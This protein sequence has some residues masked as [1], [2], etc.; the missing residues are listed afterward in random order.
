M[1]FTLKKEMMKNMED[2]MMDAVLQ[3]EQEHESLFK[4]FESKLQSIRDKHPELQDDLMVMEEIMVEIGT[5]GELYEIG[6]KQAVSIVQ[7]YGFQTATSLIV[8]SVQSA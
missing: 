1:K 5:A 7:D 3:Q 2:L 8:P 6:F 4:Q